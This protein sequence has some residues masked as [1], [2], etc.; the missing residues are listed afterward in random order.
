MANVKISGI[1]GGAKT[2]PVGTDLVEIEEA[3]GTSK[4]SSVANLTK[5]LSAA[6]TSAQGA[7]SASDKSKLDGIESGATADQTDS[8]IETAY[9]NQVSVVGQA[10]AEAGTAT[11]VRRWTAQRVAQAIAALAPSGAQTNYSA[12]TD[13]TVNDDSGDGY[14][15]GSPWVN[16]TADKAFL[17]LDATVGAA[18]WVQI[19]GFGEVTFAA[20]RIVLSESGD[21]NFKAGTATQLFGILSGTDFNMADATLQR[22]VIKDYGLTRTAPTVS[23]GA[24]TLDL[25]A[26]NAF[27][28]SLTG[29]VTTLTI[30]NP[31]TSGTL[32]K[33]VLILTQDATGSRTVT[34]PAS[35]KWEGGTAPTLTTTASRSDILVFITTD[36]GTTWYGNVIGQ[37]YS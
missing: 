9:N 11:T 16:A 22:P 29:N 6:T 27:E 17:C 34:W 3:G 5:G 4:Y 30:S 25:T 33:F 8:E 1:S 31:P 26:G 35:V 32:G 2:T 37:N 18:V 20:S 13:P 15:V 24:L 19:G 12:T 21:S 7:M 28:V 14:S 36:A 23:A 10:E